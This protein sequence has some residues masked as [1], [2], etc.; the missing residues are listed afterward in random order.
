MAQVIPV[1]M[2]GGTGSRLW[3]QSRAYFPKQFLSLVNKESMF[4]NTLSRLDNA[5]AVTDPIVVVNEEH[6]FLVAE[7][8][9]QSCRQAQAIMLEPEARNTAPAV[10]IAAMQALQKSENDDECLLLVLAAD[11][12][13][14]N[15]KAFHAAIDIAIQTAKQGKLATF[16]IVPC[17]AE[18]GYGYIK[19]GASYDDEIF[20]VDAF[21]EKPDIEK[22]ENYLASGDYFWNSGMFLFK[23]SRYIEELKLHRPDI[24]QA[25]QKAMTKTQGDL[26]FIR[27]GQEAFSEC[28]AE[29]IDY[30]V[31]EKTEDAVVIPLDAGWSDV[32]SWNALWDIAEKDESGNVAIGDV[33]CHKSD[34]SYIRSE[35]KLIATVGVKNL[36]VVESDDAILIADKHSVQD[37][38][39]IV[40]QLNTE[41]RVEAQLH[42][43]VYRPWGSYDS[44]DMGNRFQVKRICVKPGA[45]LS[46][47]KHHH[48]AEHWVVVSGTALVTKGDE[49]V[50]LTENESTYIP[51]GV[52]HRL[53]NPGKMEL[54]LIEIQSGSY[55]G[56]DDIV[57]F[58]DNYGRG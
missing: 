35:S 21:V 22:A 23:A 31:M 34:D 7:Q 15:V 6:R 30:A 26:D 57:R 56:E 28:P 1:I 55:L 3:P 18:T 27:I 45:S 24:L 42:R 10:A 11:H 36:V 54:Q 16:G 52:K 4:I 46:L 8:L 5:T 32:G 19:A 51:I 29:S 17:Y 44:V 43:K 13:I 14:D 12:V 37:V 49:S 41:Q 25:C 20:A 39:K 47:Q 40:E 48:R 33:I 53:E 9:R 2:A 50:L 58:E 38:K